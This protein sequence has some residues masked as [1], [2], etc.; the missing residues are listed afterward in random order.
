M[1]E[2]SLNVKCRNPRCNSSTFNLLC[3]VN[4]ASEDRTTHYQCSCN[5]EIDL[6]IGEECN[7]KYFEQFLWVNENIYFEWDADDYENFFV[8]SAYGKHPELVLSSWVPI[9]DY[10]KTYKLYKNL[11]NFI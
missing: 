5:T 3:W 8:G 7:A 6:L 10:D 4:Q 11:I 9:S 2:Y 1:K